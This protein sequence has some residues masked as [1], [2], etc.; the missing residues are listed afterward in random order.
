MATK[1]QV[2]NRVLRKLKRL[3]LGGSPNA[4]DAGIVEDAYDDVYA[5]LAEKN[6]VTW[7]SSDDI[8]SEA[9]RQIVK[10]VTYEVA[11]DFLSKNDEARVQ[12]YR[13]DAYGAD[14]DNPNGGAFADLV[15]LAA[16]DYTSLDEFEYY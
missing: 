3:P 7:S 1:A 14:P 6:A 8:P 5:F 9:V 12:R 13:V 2:R 16:V 10:I 15:A 4:N 11:D